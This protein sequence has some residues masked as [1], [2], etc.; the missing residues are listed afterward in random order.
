MLV[1]LIASRENIATRVTH[2]RLLVNVIHQEGHSLV[3]DWVEPAYNREGRGT[4]GKANWNDIYKESLE[5]ITK[6]DAI[7]ADATVPSFGIGYQ[8]AVATRLKKPVLLLRDAEVDQSVFANG[9]EEQ[10]LVYKTYTD[11][12]LTKHVKEFLAENNVQAKDMRFN[13][14]INRPIYNYLR[15]ASL[16]SGKTKAE[17]LRELVEREIER[18]E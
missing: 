3:L 14:F 10:A 16:K 9:I 12:T 15:W 8:V 13:F 2:L 18:K 5:A 7:V 1:H 17:I 4:I 11:S 6:A